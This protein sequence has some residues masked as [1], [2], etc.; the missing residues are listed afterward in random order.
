MAYDRT[1]FDPSTSDPGGVLAF[2]ARGTEDCPAASMKASEFYDA[3]VA[4][5]ERNGLSRWVA[6]QAWVGRAVKAAG[7]DFVR[8]K[9]GVIYKGVAIKE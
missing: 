3:Y 8:T 4:Y 6:T 1:A 2:L 9:S 7:L 5:A